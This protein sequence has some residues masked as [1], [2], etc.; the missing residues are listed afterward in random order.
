MKQRNKIKKGAQRKQAHG[1]RRNQGRSKNTKIGT[2]TVANN[3][4]NYY[5]H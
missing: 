5:Y 2:T 4:Y 1:K 3:D